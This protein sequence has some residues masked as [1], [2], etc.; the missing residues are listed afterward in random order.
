MLITRKPGQKCAPLHHSTVQACSTCTPSCCGCCFRMQFLSQPLP[1]LLLG[2]PLLLR[3]P[4]LPALMLSTGNQ[5]WNFSLI[6]DKRN[7]CTSDSAAVA[8]D[9]TDAAAVAW[10][11]ASIDADICM[12]EQTTKINIPSTYTR[13]NSVILQSQPTYIRVKMDL[14]VYRPSKNHH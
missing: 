10:P 9:A 11:N 7:F 14:K 1:L 5:P 3:Q 12:K 13:S 8:T 4:Y 2:D 6:R